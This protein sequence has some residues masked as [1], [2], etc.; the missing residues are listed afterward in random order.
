MAIDGTWAI[1]FNTPG[2]EQR[3]DLVLDT[4]QGALTG[5]FDGA[6]FEDG[7]TDGTDLSFTAHITSPF[8]LKIKTTA[9][10]DGDA[11]SGTLKAPMMKIPFTGAR[12]AS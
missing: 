7:D 3:V 2:G 1:S 6:Q 11:I 8:K 10:I 5:T 12:K 4:A 9:S